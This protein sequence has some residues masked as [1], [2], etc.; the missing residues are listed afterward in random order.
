VLQTLLGDRLPR[1][2]ANVPELPDASTTKGLSV[3]AVVEKHVSAKEFAVCHQRIDPLGFA[4]EEFD[5]IGRHRVEDSSGQVV[6]ARARAHDGA[7]FN[8][9]AGLREYI[10]SNR[11]DQLVDQF[12]RKLLGFALG[13][14]VLL[15]DTSLLDE[16]ATALK[17]NDG[18]VSAAVNAIV[19]SAQFRQIRGAEHQ[20]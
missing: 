8:G 20:P 12:N 6:D 9:V 7:E 14:R 16:M 13:R 4:L 5:T 3:R 19:L 17:A 1:P 2:P 18:R 10:L 15:S 11:R